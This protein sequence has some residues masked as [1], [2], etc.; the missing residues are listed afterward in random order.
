M[1]GVGEEAGA[2]SEPRIIA[3][4]RVA[5]GGGGLQQE[6]A[7][8][9]KC[10]SFRPVP[11]LPA[12]R[13]TSERPGRRRR[14]RPLWLP[15]VTNATQMSRVIFTSAA[16]AF[17]VAAARRRKVAARVKAGAASARAAACEWSALKGVK[18]I[19]FTQY[20]KYF[21]E[22][23]IKI[24]S[25]LV[26]GRSSAQIALPVDAFITEETSTFFSVPDSKRIRNPRNHFPSYQFS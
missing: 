24:M 23:V 3:K 10:A 25:N 13:V 5:T 6:S 9:M 2:D 19:I 16:S 17:I 4:G 8:Y 15:A 18:R 1:S 12:Q 11:H 7:S 14:A 20:D 21:I 22:Y 26:L